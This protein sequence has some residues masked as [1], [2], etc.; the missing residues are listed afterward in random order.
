VDAR[1]SAAAPS[2]VSISSKLFGAVFIPSIATI[3]FNLLNFFFE[4]YE[5]KPLPP[6]TESVYDVSVGCAFSLI[7]IAVTARDRDVTRKLVI[8]FVVLLFLI[9]SGFLLPVFLHWPK[10]YTVWLINIISICVLAWAI[11]ISDWGF[12]DMNNA[13]KES[14][15]RQRTLKYLV[16]IG[17]TVIIIVLLFLISLV[18]SNST[19][20]IGWFV[21]K[22]PIEV[23]TDLLRVLALPVL[24]IIAAAV[25]FYFGARRR[26]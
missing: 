19:H 6:L 5:T 23:S 10:L 17:V 16:A 4:H 1:G 18:I 9:L 7:G 2:V 21:D 26:K 3:I 20:N 25:G 11:L 13:D 24:S 15:K 8:S 12:L 14:A 22:R